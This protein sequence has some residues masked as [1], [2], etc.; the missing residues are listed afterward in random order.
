MSRKLVGFAATLLAVGLSF[1]LVS[2]ASA[3]TIVYK[4]GKTGSRIFYKANPSSSPD[5]TY[6]GVRTQKIM[7]PGPRIGALR[8]I[9]LGRQSV[10][11]KRIVYQLQPTNW[12]EGSNQ[13]KEY[14]SYTSVGYLSGPGRARKF[15]DRDFVVTPF[16]HYRVKY[17]VTWSKD[18]RIRG[19]LHVVYSD[20]ADYQCL[21]DLCAVNPAR[22]GWA[23]VLLEI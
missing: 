19:A 11:V 2:T 8:T 23:S 22:D 18:G 5:L 14:D 20:I 16:Q 9:G 12:G 21:S 13:W 15:S 4:K 17:R 7:V 10:V 6:G 3:Y 1:G